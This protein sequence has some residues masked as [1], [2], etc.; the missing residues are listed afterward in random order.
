MS[1]NSKELIKERLKAL[2]TRGWKSP[3]QVDEYFIESLNEIAR[4]AKEEGMREALEES[5]QIVEEMM[6]DEEY[7]QPIAK[8]I[9]ESNHRPAEE[10]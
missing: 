9:L 1:K 5:A 8:R 10:L 6:E 4:V 7:W 3:E 2:Q